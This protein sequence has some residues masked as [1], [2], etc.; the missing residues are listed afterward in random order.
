M[1]IKTSTKDQTKLIL[2][3]YHTCMFKQCCN[4]ELSVSINVKRSFKWIIH[5]I[6]T[7]RYC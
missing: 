3:Y 1:D 7:L 2:F 6:N 4:K 5:F